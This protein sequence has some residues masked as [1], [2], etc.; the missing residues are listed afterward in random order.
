MKSAA[1]V[2]LVGTI[3]ILPVSA[4]ALSGKD[5]L[6][7]WRRA[8]DL[9]KFALTVNMA[10][11]ANKPG[12]NSAYLIACIDEVAEGEGLGSQKLSTVAAGCIVLYGM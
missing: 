2:L 12:V 9:E 1:C 5:T 6:A 3:G 8:S 11:V 7:D 10:K 4:F